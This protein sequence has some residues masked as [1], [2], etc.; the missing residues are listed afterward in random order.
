VQLDPTAALVIITLVLLVLAIA[1]V[2]VSRLSDHIGRK[3]I[4]WAGCALLI[5]VSVPAFSLMH[6]GGGYPVVFAGALL[7]GIMLLC[8]LGTE[9][10]TLP[11]LFPTNVRYGAVAVAYNI[12]VSAFGGT[13]PLIAE[14]LVSGTGNVQIPTYILIVAGGIGAIAEFLPPEPAHRHPPGTA[15]H[16]RTH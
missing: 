5:V 11:A 8:F 2:F 9:P 7:V 4:M 6:S 13:T 15:P 1:V 16:T 3:P 14:A 12:S 10:S